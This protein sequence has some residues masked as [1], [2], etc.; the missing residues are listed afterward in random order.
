VAWDAIHGCSLI[1]ANVTDALAGVQSYTIQ[2]KNT[3]GDIV[4][5][6]SGEALAFNFDTAEKE[7]T[8][9]VE[10]YDNA[11]NFT[12]TS[13]LVYEDDDQD[14][15]IMNGSGGAIDL[16]DQCPLVVPTLDI[17]KDGCQDVPVVTVD[18]GIAL[19]TDIY[20]GN[21]LT[22]IFPTTATA[23]FADTYTKNNKIWTNVSAYIDGG[24]TTNYA[25]G[26]MNKQ[27]E[28][29]DEMHCTFNASTLATP[30]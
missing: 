14:T 26:L 22:S 2:L 20:N 25:L 9:V 11:G 19:C 13:Q 1:Q 24:Y 12:T 27:G 29:K 3:S 30:A 18:T 17:D 4:A 5:Q 10:T 15:F 21:A 16:F 23:T 7:W 6:S 8:I 28:N